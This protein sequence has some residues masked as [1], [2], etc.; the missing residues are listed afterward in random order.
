MSTGYSRVAGAIE[1]LRGAQ[2]SVGHAK[3]ARLGPDWHMREALLVRDHLDVIHLLIERPDDSPRIDPLLGDAFPV[4]WLEASAESPHERIDIACSDSELR[5]TFFSLIGEMLDRVEATRH[6]VYFELAAVVEDW[7]RA[8]ERVRLRT[9]RQQAVGL[10]GEL[11]VLKEIAAVRPAD[12]L[13][14]WRGPDGYRH[15]FFSV[16]ALEVKSYLGLDSPSVTIHGAHQLDPPVKGRLHLAALRLEENAAGQ[17][18]AEILDELEELGLHRGALRGRTT[19]DAPLVDDAQFRF[20]V[21]ERR[22]Y[23]VTDDFPG[24]RASKLD[25]AALSGVARLSYQLLLDTCPSP[26]P[27]EEFTQVLEHL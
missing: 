17:T 18:V 26:R 5:P 13:K 16:N 21:A 3:A 20:I 27:V 15:D 23:E 1:R 19:P 7:R 4:T 14:L 9:S 8:L 11:V 10:F 12:A 25:P 2:P 22:L 6:S 24:I